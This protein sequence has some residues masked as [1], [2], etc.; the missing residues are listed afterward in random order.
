MKAIIKTHTKIISVI[1]DAFH[2]KVN[3]KN[4]GKNGRRLGKNYLKI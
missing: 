1:G 3:G 4:E 2:T